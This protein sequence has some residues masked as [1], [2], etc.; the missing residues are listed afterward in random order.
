MSDCEHLY[1]DL[2]SLFTTA[3]IILPSNV[4]VGGRFAE[5]VN[6]TVNFDD[7]CTNAQG[8]MIISDAENFCLRLAEGIDVNSKKATL[9]FR[10]NSRPKALTYNHMHNTVQ[11]GFLQ[12]SQFVILMW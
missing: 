4:I 1:D 5:A 10:D 6:E 8:H 9:R 12:E 2:I 7:I 11:K 3:S